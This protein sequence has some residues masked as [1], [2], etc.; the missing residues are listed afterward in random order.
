MKTIKL[1][2]LMLIALLG[3]TAC[4]SDDDNDNTTVFKYTGN[5]TVTVDK[6]YEPV[7]ITCQVTKNDNGTIDVEIPEYTLGGTTIG[8]LTIGHVVIKNI[9][10]DKE[11]GAYSRVYG[12]DGLSM[13]F[14][15]ERGGKATMDDDYTFKED[16]YIKVV[17]TEQEAI[18]TNNFSF[19]RMPFRIVTVFEGER[20]KL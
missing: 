18:I 8:D 20:N 3:M 17:Q 9:G 15:A 6:T 11:K 13:H 16:S 12:A 14:K 10:Y 2:S 7:T 5:N 19:G 1:L 4:S